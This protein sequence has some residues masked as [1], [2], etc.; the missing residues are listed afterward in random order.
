[1]GVRVTD[2]RCGNGQCTGAVL[3]KSV[4]LES[5]WVER[6][7]RKCGQVAHIGDRRGNE[8]AVEL[9]CQGTAHRHTLAMGS[10]HWRGIAVIYCDRCKTDSAITPASP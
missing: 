10:T 1:M 7:C 2:W 4:S 3:A 8:A 5:G 6:K 9:K